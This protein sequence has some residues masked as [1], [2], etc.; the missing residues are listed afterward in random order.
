MIT[1]R[2]QNNIKFEMKEELRKKMEEKFD[3]GRKPLNGMDAYI[4]INCCVEDVAMYIVCLLWIN[5]YVKV[6]RN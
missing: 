2:S 1:E 6:N 3:G 5:H 4:I